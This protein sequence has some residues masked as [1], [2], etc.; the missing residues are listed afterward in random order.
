MPLKFK[1]D[2]LDNIDDSLKTHYV[3]QGDAY[4]LN[5]EGAVSKDK[6]NEFRDNNVSL[7]NKLAAFDGIDPEKYKNMS[8]EIK[9]LQAKK[10]GLSEAEVEEMVNTQVKAMKTEYEN[11]IETLTKDNDVLNSQLAVQ[12]IDNK[13]RAAATTHKVLDTAVDDVIMRAKSTFQMKDGVAKS[14]DDEGHV[15]FGKDGETPLTID[16]WVQDLS[17]SAPHL[18]VQSTGSGA[19]Q[20]VGPNGMKRADMSPMNKISAGLG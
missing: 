11:K 18:F 16:S 9:A 3:Q 10:A 6:L 12:L 4:F 1:V 20:Q 17:K 14:Y 8:S 19:N 2:N 7:T 13:V 5:V 15:I